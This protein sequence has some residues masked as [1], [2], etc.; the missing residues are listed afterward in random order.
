MQHIESLKS[1]IQVSVFPLICEIHWHNVNYL[2]NTI[3]YTIS[4][5]NTPQGYSLRRDPLLFWQIKEE[6]VKKLRDSLQQ[7]KQEAKSHGEELR[8]EA[9]AKVLWCS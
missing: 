5:K 4:K 9:L 7:Q 1:S 6:E 3:L 2:V 8:A